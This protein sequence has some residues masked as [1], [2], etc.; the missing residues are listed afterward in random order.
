[1][2]IAVR[3]RHLR[4]RLRSINTWVAAVATTT[5]LGGCGAGYYWQA[6]MGHLE[7]MRQRRPVAAVIEDP[8]TPATVR[9]KLGIA[10]QAL[11]FAHATLALPDNGSYSVYADTGRPFV[12]WNVVAAP[13]FGLA[14]RTWC[15]P[16]AGC[17]SYRGYFD[18]QQAEEFA[19]ALSVDGDDVF[20]GGVAAYSTLG[21][22]RDPLLNTMIGYSDEQ[23][24][25]LIFHE[26][27]HQRI[28][29]RDDSSF[30]EGFASFVEEHGVRA[31]L[32]ARGADDRLCRYRLSLARRG[33]VEALLAEY[34]DR[35]GALYGRDLDAAEAR[36]RKARVFE[37]LAND[38]RELRA[39][40]A[41]P[42]H[43]DHWFDGTMNNARLAAFATYDEHVPAFAALLDEAGGDLQAFYG[44]AEA[45][46]ALGASERTAAMRE[47]RDRG[48]SAPAIA[49]GD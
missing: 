47:L 4:R 21:R 49:C 3:H 43:Y 9:A 6:S 27:A 40:W 16:V 2:V 48:T 15:F 25:G 10:S 26:L 17:I 7:L 28:Y 39:A 35:L 23:M 41:A 14:P 29:V 32:E 42:P 20:V 12:V 31:W 24:A 18:E 1:M 8:Q 11:E 33:L 22:F 19:A 46:A 37:E 5:L 38:Y 13:E 30:N 34:R 36:R 45:L 44:R